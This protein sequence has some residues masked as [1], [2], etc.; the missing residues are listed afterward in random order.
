MPEGTQ[1]RSEAD[2][3]ALIRDLGGKLG[4]QLNEQR[5][6]NI[7]RFEEIEKKFGPLL[8]QRAVRESPKPAAEVARELEQ[9]PEKLERL[10]R[11]PAVTQNE[12]LLL[13]QRDDE[14]SGFE[15]GRNPRKRIGRLVMARA[16]AYTER[17]TMPDA[18]RALRFERDADEFTRALAST[19]SG[20]GADLIPDA[21]SPDFI[22][23]LRPFTVVR[24]SGATVLGVPSGTLDIG[25]QNGTATVSWV[26]D[27]DS[28]NESSLT[29]GR[30]R[31]NA[32]KA[33]AISA[34]SNDL[35]RR[36]V[37]GADGLVQDDLFSAMG[38][39]ED[40]RALRGLGSSFTPK[41]V[42]YQTA[43]ANVFNA[44]GTFNFANALIDVTKMI[45]LVAESNIPDLMNGVHIMPWRSYFALLAVAGGANL[46][47]ASL[48]TELR[49]MS[50]LGFKLMCTTQI[51]TNLG[52]GGTESENYFG[53]PR[54]VMIGEALAREIS[55]ADGAA[56]KNSSGT[57]VSGFSQDETAIRIITEM[58]VQ[59]RHTGAFSVLSATNWI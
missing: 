6:E 13:S 14:R 2:V 39:E 59:L 58:D 12:R 9:D 26:G 32:R 44:N 51:P 42:R 24:A 11:G 30:T 46:Q 40:Y 22:E 28:V 31:F 49:S 27:A 41:G 20:A 8:A 43:T 50:L 21:Y 25:R 23:Y 45:R 4:T 37:P 35:I 57:L 34:V 3:A 38:V 29:T 33:M 53:V 16:K 47:G 15:P 18:L 17:C 48:W 1:V 55:V 52:G 56:Y 54:H 36:S 5:D 7:R 19:T 10:A